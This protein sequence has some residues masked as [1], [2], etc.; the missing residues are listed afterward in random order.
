MCFFADEGPEEHPLFWW[1][2]ACGFR[3]VWL[4]GP[5]HRLPRDLELVAR[6]ADCWSMVLDTTFVLNFNMAPFKSYAWYQVALEGLQE[7]VAT[8]DPA[9]LLFVELYEATV[10]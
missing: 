8:A 5:L 4:L 3:T 10:G 9:D 6:Q 1:M 7:Y 2:A